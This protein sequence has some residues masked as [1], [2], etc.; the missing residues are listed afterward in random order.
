MLAGSNYETHFASEILIPKKMIF[1]QLDRFFEDVGEVLE[2]LSLDN[3]LSPDLEKRFYETRAIVSS[4]AALIL[5]GT[6]AAV[7]HPHTNSIVM[8]FEGYK[9]ELGQLSP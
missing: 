4:A 1:D 8:G 5:Y 7:V 6:S 3:S 2:T 9:V